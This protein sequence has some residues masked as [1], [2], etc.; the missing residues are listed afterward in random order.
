M[1]RLKCARCTTGVIY[2]DGEE[3]VC[4]NCGFRPYGHAPIDYAAWQWSTALS[5]DIDAG[6]VLYPQNRPEPLPWVRSERLC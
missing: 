3:V 6:S 5:P 4:M 1:S 2:F